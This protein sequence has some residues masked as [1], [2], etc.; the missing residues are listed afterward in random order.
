AGFRVV[1][2]GVIGD[3]LV[4]SE[5]LRLWREGTGLGTLIRST[6]PVVVEAIRAAYP[7]LV[8]YLARV[9][10][11]PVAE[12]RYL[13]ELYGAGVKVVYAGLSAAPGAPELDAS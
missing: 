5:Y 9:V 4:A 12:A 8:P 7:E 13:R 10:T 1:S 3:E 11:P 2:R 6:D